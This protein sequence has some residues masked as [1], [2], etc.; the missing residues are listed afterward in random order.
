MLSLY[1]QKF[2]PTQRIVGGKTVNIGAVQR[3]SWAEC[4]RVRFASLH[5]FLFEDAP[6]DQGR[7][8]FQSGFEAGLDGG[9]GGRVGG[10]SGLKPDFLGS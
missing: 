10:S 6:T 8:G 9:K 3:D 1:E 7:T 2:V 5:A 4:T